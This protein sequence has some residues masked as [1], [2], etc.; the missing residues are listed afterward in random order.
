MNRLLC[1][2]FPAIALVGSASPSLAHVTG[3]SAPHWHATDTW[4][5]V[6]VVALTIA[7]AWFAR[8]RR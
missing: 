8:R 5:L 4:G 3:S 1:F 2:L 7:A 6:A